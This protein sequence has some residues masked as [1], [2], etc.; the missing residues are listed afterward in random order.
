MIDNNKHDNDNNNNNHT[1]E[2]QALDY[3]KII[4]ILQLKDITVFMCIYIY[5]YYEPQASG[6]AR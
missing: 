3:V 1:T 4:N 2:P 5:I 6:A